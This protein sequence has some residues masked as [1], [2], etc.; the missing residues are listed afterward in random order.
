MT[1]L[2]YSFKV[3][4]SVKYAFFAGVLVLL[5]AIQVLIAL[6]ALRLRED[7]RR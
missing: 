5:A 4:H 7:L 2:A 1:K 6:S 3:P